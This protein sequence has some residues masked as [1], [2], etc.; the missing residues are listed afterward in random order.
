MALTIFGILFIGFMT[1]GV[2]FPFIIDDPLWWKLIVGI[3]LSGFV[4]Y[5]IDVLYRQKPWLI[6][7]MN[8]LWHKN[9]YTPHCASCKSL[10]TTGEAENILT[11]FCR[12]DIIYL[13]FNGC[14][15]TLT[16][17]REKIKSY[18]NKHRSAEYIPF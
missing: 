7:G 18:L 9:R 5:P 16:E 10:L 2:K 15:I 17:A 8:I 4:S 14:P 12:K 1:W 13:R 6:P 11:C 3:G